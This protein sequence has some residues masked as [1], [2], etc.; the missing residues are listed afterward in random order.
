VIP[1]FLIL[2]ILM[3]VLWI[4]GFFNH[5]PVVWATAALLLFMGVVLMAIGTAT[6][7]RAELSFKGPEI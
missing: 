5:L 1:N 3:E 4:N 2:L 6:L 7:H